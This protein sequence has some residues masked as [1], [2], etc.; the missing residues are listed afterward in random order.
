MYKGE[1][2]LIFDK[3]RKVIAYH[4][5]TVNGNRMIVSVE[6]PMPEWVKKEVDKIRASIPIK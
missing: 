4:T 3:T 2:N 1:G 5:D 6:R